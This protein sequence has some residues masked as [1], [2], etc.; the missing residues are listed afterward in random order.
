[1]SVVGAA[2]L[3]LGVCGLY[4]PVL[5]GEFLYDDLWYLV[6]NPFLAQALSF[7]RLFTDPSVTAAAQSGLSQDVY[8]PFTTLWFWIDAHVWGHSPFPFH[9]E[10]LLLHLL[11]G[12]LVYPLLKRAT[13]E[14]RM[15]W[16]GTAAF[17]LHPVQVQ[18]VAWISQRS[19]LAATACLLGALLCLYREQ[20]W[21]LLLSFA[22]LLFRESA[23]VF[24]FLLG[25]LS[26]QE[27]RLR[28]YLGLSLIPVGI[29]LAMRWSVLGQWSQFQNEA[30]RFEN[31]G[32]GIA[33]LP[34]YIGKLVLPMHL[35]VS[36]SYPSFTPLF[37]AMAIA[38]WLAY[39]AGIAI[40][41]RSRRPV[42]MG[43]LWILAAL[44]PVL[45]I[46]PIRT[47]VA[48][49]FLYLPLIGFLAAVVYF[50]RHRMAVAV[51]AGWLVYLTG[52][53]IAAMPAWVSERSLWQEA[54]RHDSGNAFAR[55][56]YASTLSGQEAIQQYLLAL[57][58]HPNPEMA[59][60]AMNNLA[61]VYTE[62]KDYAT[63]REWGQKSL[64]LKKRMTP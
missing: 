25:I 18:S 8:R 26:W 22:A 42:A 43:M 62:E 37:T 4:L 40:C 14:N 36:Y 61:A 16:L 47:F 46:L 5:K 64:A 51:F 44:L 45:H 55:I 58:S 39:C 19:T 34:V 52:T 59:F 56:C 49:R 41:F 17:L 3:G 2:L 9:L 28:K 63:A 53:S 54:V 60:A 23:V 29:Y 11:N 32:L 24:P 21:G 48:E 57:E 33:A 20:P 50:V 30:L 35:R 27:P 10:N 7:K 12:A 6:H 38:V 31:L 13:G 1:M 15:A